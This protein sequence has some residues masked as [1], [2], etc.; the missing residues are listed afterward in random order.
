MLSTGV[1]GID[2]LDERRGVGTLRAELGREDSLGDVSKETGAG[3]GEGFIG[4]GEEIRVSPAFG[5]ELEQGR[6]GRFDV[7]G[8]RISWVGGSKSLGTHLSGRARLTSR[9]S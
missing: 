9:S 3:A 6:A 1:R 2:R 5:V 8:I 7:A 4:G